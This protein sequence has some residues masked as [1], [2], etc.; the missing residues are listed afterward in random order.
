MTPQSLKVES[1]IAEQCHT[2]GIVAAVVALL[3]ALVVSHGSKMDTAG[4]GKAGGGVA[5]STLP[6]REEEEEEDAL[7]YAAVVRH[8]GTL[9][10]I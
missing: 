7:V 2:A 1:N 9:D 10:K 5:G 8:G 6:G 3:L 4:V